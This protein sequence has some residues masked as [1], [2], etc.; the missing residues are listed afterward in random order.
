MDDPQVDIEFDIDD[1]N[2]ED[3]KGAMDFSIARKQKK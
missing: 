2:D 3:R 1:D